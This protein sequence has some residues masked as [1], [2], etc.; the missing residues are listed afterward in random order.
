MTHTTKPS[1]S[2]IDQ[3]YERLMIGLT[4]KFTM[5]TFQELR[6]ENIDEI[7]GKAKNH[8]DECNMLILYLSKEIE[9]LNIRLI[10]EKITDE[11][12]NKINIAIWRIETEIGAKEKYI[13][14]YQNR[15]FI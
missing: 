8:L 3:C 4:E 12:K 10:D 1:T 14:R 9:F 5:R 13:D 7:K 15:L 2:V 6:Q 11:V